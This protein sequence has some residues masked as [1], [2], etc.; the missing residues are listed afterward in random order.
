MAN[1]LLTYFLDAM[2]AILVFLGMQVVASVVFFATSGL[3]DYN[4]TDSFIASIFAIPISLAVWWR[5]IRPRIRKW[6]SSQRRLGKETEVMRKLSDA[7]WVLVNDS[8]TRTSWTR[9]GLT[10]LA[11]LVDGELVLSGTGANGDVFSHTKLEELTD[12]T[13]DGRIVRL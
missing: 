12:R 4:N 11:E 8:G 1:K 13:S 9:D 7:G 5:W 2:F 6:L 10:L 3:K